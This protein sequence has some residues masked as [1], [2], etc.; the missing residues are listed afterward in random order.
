MV[1]LDHRVA[2][3]L[4]Q[5]A[6][7][8]FGEKVRV[9]DDTLALI[10][11]R[12]EQVTKFIKETGKPAYGF[13]R[14][15]GS[16][17]DK[18]VAPDQ[19]EQL[20]WNLIRSH[21]CGVGPAAPREVVRSAMFLR[22]VSLTRG[23]S[24]IRPVVVEQLVRFLNEEIVP[25]VPFFGSVGASGDLAPLSH[26]A[27]SL[28]GE[29][30]VVGAQG[31]PLATAEVLASKGIAPLVLGMKEGLA[32]NNGMQFTA[33]LAI[34]LCRRMGILLGQAT[35]NTAL[36]VQVLLGSDTPF[37]A[38]LHAL[39]P[40]PGAVAVAKRLSALLAH[41]PI[42]AS[43]QQ[44]DVDGVVQD[45]YS[46][47]CSAQILGACAELLDDARNTLAIEANSVTDN[48]ILLE[49]RERPGEFTDIVS[50]GHFHG[51]PLATRIYGLLEAAG[52][53][54]RLS[55]MRC[56][57]YVD[58]ARNRG[59]GH[60]LKWPELSPEQ[61]ATSSAMMIPEYVSA[62]LTNHVWG[63]AMPSHLFSLSTDAGQEDHVSMA[64]GLAA[65]AWEML[66]RLSELLAIELAYS[67]QAAAI[68]RIQQHFPSKIPLSAEEK[69]TTRSALDAYQSAVQEVARPHHFVVEVRTELQYAWKPEERLLC[70]WC[71]AVLA[72][73]GEQFA[74]VKADRFM[75]PQ[76]E[77]LK[78]L[79]SSG[80]LLKDAPVDLVGQSTALSH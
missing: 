68:R 52:I 63:A 77:A 31:E 67:A 26:I 73:V 78:S 42:R 58:S 2:V 25:L 79:V 11:E 64:A 57:R 76:L 69:A 23:H 61:D 7:V 40:H 3:T 47:R 38:D 8:G 45:P 50:G 21:A 5:V 36:A 72:K 51:M 41:S 65:R 29:G 62:A 15:F 28:M 1:L 20:Q 54:A 71:E 19:L 80:E 55:N 14:G 6:S 12:R 37:R 16:N 34:H 4:E 59:L 46:L 17:V 27:L 39:R 70:P 32:L 35:L 48:P 24:G 18:P 44:Y 30:Q 33:A 9:S 10:S 53:M 22:A 74:P 13:N 43:H 49:S 60:D 56:N 75:A 66:P